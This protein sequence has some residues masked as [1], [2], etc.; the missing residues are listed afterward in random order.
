MGESMTHAKLDF[1]SLADSGLGLNIRN[2]NVP[3]LTIA[4]DGGRKL[5][6]LWADGRVEG[7][8]EDS[9]PAAE[10]FIRG[11][12]GERETAEYWRNEY[13]TAQDVI[14]ELREIIAAAKARAYK[15][16]TDGMI[17]LVQILDS[18]V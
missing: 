7:E 13:E 6:S 5:L 18:E 17:G 15:T 9:G 14:N 1:I 11:L 8:I 16:P 4:G 12:L 10:R 3:I 2:P